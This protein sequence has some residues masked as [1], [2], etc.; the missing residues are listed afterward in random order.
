MR[1]CLMK[2]GSLIASLSLAIYSSSYASVTFDW[3]TV[4]NPD[5]IADT[6]AMASDGT[7]GYGSVSYTYRIS[8]TEVTYAQYAE[9]LN[10]VAETP[11]ILTY[12]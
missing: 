12:S 5:N 1:R 6:K 2:T 7:T 9:F 11:D 10:A 8:K 3:A 4:G